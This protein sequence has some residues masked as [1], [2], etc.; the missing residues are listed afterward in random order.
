MKN[1]K[2]SD[3]NK[4]KSIRNIFYGKKEIAHKMYYIQQAKKVN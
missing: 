3:K 4:R 1:Y 2:T